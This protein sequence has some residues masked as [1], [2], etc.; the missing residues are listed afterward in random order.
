MPKTKA[1]RKKE[2]LASGEYLKNP[3]SDRLIKRGGETHKKLIEDGLLNKEGKI[4][5]ERNIKLS[6][7]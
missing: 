1:Q 4:T 5:E 7:D 2:K 6:Q 3:L